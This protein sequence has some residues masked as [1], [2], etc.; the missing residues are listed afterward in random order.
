MQSSACTGSIKMDTVDVR[1]KC[2]YS[3]DVTEMKL[4]EKQ[5]IPDVTLV[6]SSGC[7]LLMAACPSQYVWW[8]AY[9]HFVHVCTISEVRIIM[10]ACY[11]Y[12]L[13]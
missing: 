7:C 4:M 2:Q 10:Y 3:L 11:C 5:Q 6:L 1:L 8:C 13:L 9:A 12:Y